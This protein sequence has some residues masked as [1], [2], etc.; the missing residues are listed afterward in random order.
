MEIGVGEADAR[1]EELLRRVEAGE[2]IV[3][4][5][6]GR[7]VAVLSPYVV[8]SVDRAAAFGNAAGQVEQGD[9]FDA[10]LP[11]DVAAVFGA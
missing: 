6:G 9:D 10:S 11:D 2:R 1:L 7:P 5:R 3:L 4:T 8:S